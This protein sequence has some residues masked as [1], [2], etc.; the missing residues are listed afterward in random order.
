MGM[1]DRY[2]K[3]GGF[4]QLLQ[5]LETSPVAK[6]EQFLTLIAGESPIWEEA[7]RKKILTIT[8]VY[9]WDGQYLVEIFSRVQPMTLAYALHGSPPEQIESLLSCLPPISKRK[10]TDLMAETNPSA[11]EKGTCVSKMV[12]EVRGFVSQGIIRLEKVDPELHIPENI[13][14]LLNS[15]VHSIPVYSNEPA[16][17]DSAPNI[18]GES[19]DNPAAQQEMDFLKRKVNQLASEVNA[20]KHENT[21]LKDKL[22]QIKKIA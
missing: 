13:E 17:K 6:R 3:K 22:S 9:S 19:D 5:L 15:S 20:L 21:V 18:V 4:Y 2:K 8:R 14:E 12:S 7:L 1:L 10:I 16:K 11:A